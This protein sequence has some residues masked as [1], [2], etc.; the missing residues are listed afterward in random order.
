[1]GVKFVVVSLILVKT[2]GKLR[3]QRKVKMVADVCYNSI[4]KRA[5]F[6]TNK[7]ARGTA[8]WKANREVLV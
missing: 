5:S 3:F 4:N 7:F 1:M 6:M 2:Q 8:K